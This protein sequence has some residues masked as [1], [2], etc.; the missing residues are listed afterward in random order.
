V[1]GREAEHEHLWYHGTE[2]PGLTEFRKLKEAPIGSNGT[3]MGEGTYLTRDRSLA[4]EWAFRGDTGPGADVPSPY[5]AE[6]QEWEHGSRVG[7]VLGVQFQPKNPARFAYGKGVPDRFEQAEAARKEGHDAIMDDNVAVSFKPHKNANIV[8]RMAYQDLH[9]RG[10]TPE[11]AA[12][13]A[14]AEEDWRW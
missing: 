5:S 8:K 14:D 4:E 2:D 6:R 11:Q 7:R 3:D 12:A 1:A 10:W 13:E 9:W